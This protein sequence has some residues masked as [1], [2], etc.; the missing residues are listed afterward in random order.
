MIARAITIT[1]RKAIDA[2]IWIGYILLYG[3]RPESDSFFFRHGGR[4]IFEGEVAFRQLS[5]KFSGRIIHGRGDSFK[6]VVPFY[7]EY[8]IYGMA[9]KA[10]FEF[11]DFIA[12]F[13]SDSDCNC[14]TLFRPL[15]EVDFYLSWQRAI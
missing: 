5:E 7:F 15:L 10:R 1:V 4:G 9:E 13:V 2:N 8:L 6:V 11:A 3:G 12:G 14:V